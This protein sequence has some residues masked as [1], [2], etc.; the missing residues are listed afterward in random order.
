VDDGDVYEYASMHARAMRAV[1]ERRLDEAERIGRDLL[2]LA[3]RMWGPDSPGVA[4]ALG[5]VAMILR[6]GGS[7]YLEQ[8]ALHQRALRIQEDAF[9]PEHADVINSLH[10]LGLALQSL[11]REE[12]ALVVFRRA[13]Q[14]SERALGY[15]ESVGL[16]RELLRET[17]RLLLKMHRPE[18]AIP[19]LKREARLSD[20]SGYMRGRLAALAMLARAL[21]DARKPNNAIRIATKALRIAENERGVEELA[22]RLREWLNEARSMQT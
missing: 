8:L 2:N 11:G 7:R 21:L 17:A 18:E 13:L 14:T 16:P 19:L 15:E 22:D 20:A 6:L 5:F 12:E 3:E 1:K 4:P 10:H 9:G